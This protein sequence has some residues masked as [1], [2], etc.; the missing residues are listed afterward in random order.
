MFHPR[1]DD[2]RTAPPLGDAVICRIEDPML[3]PV[4]QA[5]SLSYRIEPVLDVRKCGC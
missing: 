1:E 5:G 4:P 2:D 3:D